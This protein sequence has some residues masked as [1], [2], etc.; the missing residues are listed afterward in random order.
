M[1]KATKKVNDNMKRA[2]GWAVQVYDSY[3]CRL[4]KDSSPFVYSGTREECEA[5]AANMNAGFS[6][7]AAA[8]YLK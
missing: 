4:G 8:V 3:A 7:P 2:G 1:K 5:M 6:G